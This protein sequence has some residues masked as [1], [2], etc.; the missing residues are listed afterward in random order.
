MAKII[1]I[2][3]NQ[4][5]EKLGMFLNEPAEDYH[6]TAGFVSSS[7]LPE[8]EESPAHFVE[9]WQNGVE[10]TPAMDNGNF[11][12]SLLLEQ[13]IEKFVAR[14]VKEDGSLVRSNSKEYAAFLAANE[15]KT[16]IAPELFNQA[17]EVLNA[18]CLN[19]N[20]VKSF[21]ECVAE[22]SFYAVDTETGL[23][24]KARTDLIPKDLV[25]A[26]HDK[27]TTALE[28]LKL[29]GGL[30]LHDLKSTSNIRGFERQIFLMGYDVRLIHY[31]ETIRAHVKNSM[32]F[33]LGPVQ[34]LKF[35]AIESS[36]PY[37]SK[38]YKL[39]PHQIDRAAAKWRAYIN[40]IFAC[41]NDGNFPCYSDDW[42]LTDEP[43]FLNTLSEEPTF[44]AGAF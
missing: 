19:K 4:K 10:P 1:T 21:D 27:D 33:D 31:W 36:A 17:Y 26:I 2:K 37:G 24:L 12:H 16:P 13:A 11:L 3:P 39:K 32:S 35:T 42:I 20:Y 44:N 5:P 15:G 18:A 8:L 6:S 22:V 23:P 34:D 43:A 9:K 38:N 7:P 41:M 40:T 30:Y 14:P 28:A 25:K 29:S